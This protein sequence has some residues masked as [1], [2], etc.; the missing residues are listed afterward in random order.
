MFSL[1]LYLVTL[2][3]VGLWR[4]K[5]AKTFEEFFLSN[6]RLGLFE[7]CL[8]LASTWVDAAIILGFAGYCYSFG[9]DALW[10]AIPTSI[11]VYSFSIFFA[12]RINLKG[13]GFTVGELLREVYGRRVS[14]V[15]SFFVL[16]Y[17]IALIGANIMAGGYIMESIFKIPFL[18]GVALTLFFTLIY[19]VLGGFKKVV[20]TDILQFFLVII[21]LFVVFFFSV[22]AVGGWGKIKEIASFYPPA[23]S[24]WDIASF[25]IVFTFPFWAD[26]SFYQRCS[27]ARDPKVASLGVAFVGLI[28]SLMTIIGLGIGLAGAQ[29][30][31]NGV[32]PDS[33]FPSM[34]ETLLP[35]GLREFVG[36]SVLSA[37]MS[38]ADSYLLIAGGVI[39]NDILRP[40]GFRYNEITLAKV[41]ALLSA[42]LAFL[43][44][45]IFSDIIDAAV[46]AFS[47]FS[48]TS[49][50]PLILAL[51]S[52]AQRSFSFPSILGM[53]A[54]GIT[55]ISWKLLNL[56]DT[57]ISAL[58]GLLASGSV[59]LL[60]F[61][62]RR[63]NF[64][65]ESE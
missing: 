45:S 10:L 47:L 5:G 6:R 22:K 3:V 15:S 64:L 53:F 4:I 26:P 50:I 36:L 21:G 65:K 61:T 8:T 33:I 38:T 57:S 30:I 37:V 42:M 39:A 24:K 44:L 49:L 20:E 16:F 28:D 23:F 43:S 18:Y 2:S 58:Y 54:G 51:V 60:F 31:G 34:V 56:G 48:S 1:S 59:W 55:V 40:L 27:A 11:G 29:L 9:Y 25:F 7:T 62:F 17:S 19:T 12:R 46:F 35:Q 13:N 41:G 52:R 32:N 14:I 63:F